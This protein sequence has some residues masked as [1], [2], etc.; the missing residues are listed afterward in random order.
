VRLSYQKYFDPFV[1]VVLALLAVRTDLLRRSDYVGLG[2]LC[3]A[4][5][6]YA[7]SFA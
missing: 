6:A 3:A 5:V 2:L 1:L 4:F 7:L